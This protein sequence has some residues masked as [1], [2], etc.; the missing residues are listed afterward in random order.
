MARHPVEITPMPPSGVFSAAGRFTIAY[1][2]SAGDPVMLTLQVPAG[3]SV[4]VT[5]LDIGGGEFRVSDPG[6]TGARSVAITV[7]PGGPKPVRVQV[8]FVQ[9]SATYLV[10]FQF[11]KPALPVTHE[12]PEGE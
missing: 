9:G 6:G 2:F 5:P 11:V 1:T 7:A 4:A 10:I 12:A 8:A 3:V